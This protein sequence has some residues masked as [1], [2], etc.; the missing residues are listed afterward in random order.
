VVAKE[1]GTDVSRSTRLRKEQSGEATCESKLSSSTS[2]TRGCTSFAAIPTFPRW[3]G[4]KDYEKRLTK[5]RSANFRGQDPWTVASVRVSVSCPGRMGKAIAGSRE[6]RASAIR[7]KPCRQG[8]RFW[9][10]GI[11]RTE[12]AR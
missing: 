1:I 8:S 11:V 9:K 6:F 5:V 4:T 7:K 3:A 2:V 10:L 12:E